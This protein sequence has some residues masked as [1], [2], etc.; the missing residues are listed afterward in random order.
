V[1]VVHGGGGATLGE[2]VIVV[3]ELGRVAASVPFIGSAVLGV[4]ALLSVAPGSDRDELLRGVAEG[5]VRLAVAVA[6][7]SDAAVA[8]PA[9][10]ATAAGRVSGTATFVLDA[11]AADHLLLLVDGGRLACVPADAVLVTDQPVVDETRNFATVVADEVPALLWPLTVDPQSVLDR[12]ALAVAFDSLG[13][14]EAMLGRTVTYARERQQFGRPIGS[15]QA[16]KHQCA[17]ALV[18]ITV[19]RELLGLAVEAVVGDD[20][21]A[22]RLVAMATA[23]TGAAAVEVAGT[24]MQLHGGIGYT[25]ESGVHTYLKRA[26]LNRSLFGAPAEHR[27]RVAARYRSP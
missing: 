25:W 3:E 1:P 9:F 26:T 8:A 6:P 4:G 11:T 10:M 24:A 12:G 27:R 17:D 21:E 20:P 15:F 23:H 2:T 18:A 16:V 14:A 22:G 7:S 13:V 5:L 19:S